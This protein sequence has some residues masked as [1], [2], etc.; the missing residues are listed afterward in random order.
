MGSRGGFADTRR[1][2][3]PN[4]ENPRQK[5]LEFEYDPAKSAANK[6]K[7]GI[8]F[9]EAKMLWKDDKRVVFDVD[10][11]GEARTITVGL[12]NGK[13]Y[14]AVTTIR[15][16]AIRIISV[17]RSRDNEVKLYEQDN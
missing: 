15:G 7:H 8:D 12:Y 2:S 6:E 3:D 10:S 17:R 16:D 4:P 1:V 11:K 5:E 9:E 13:M 14:S